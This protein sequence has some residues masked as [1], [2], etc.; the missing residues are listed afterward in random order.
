VLWTLPTG[1]FNSH[2]LTVDEGVLYGQSDE[3]QLFAVDAGN[4]SILP[5]EFETGGFSD[6]LHYAVNDGVVY[7]AGPDGRVYAHAV[8]RWEEGQARPNGSK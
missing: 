3:G 2:F 1:D 5:W 7:S 4:G 8:W 6:V